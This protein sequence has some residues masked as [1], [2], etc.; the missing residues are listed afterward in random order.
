[1]PDALTRIRVLRR[2]GYRCMAREGMYTCGKPAP[3]VGMD[4]DH[5]VAMCPVHAPI[6]RPV[7]RR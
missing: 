3:G 6:E 5:L 7:R 2:D 4:G 1:M